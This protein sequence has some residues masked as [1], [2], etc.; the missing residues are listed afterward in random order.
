MPN[1][2]NRKAAQRR[3][4]EGSTRPG[5]TLPQLRA[6]VS[7]RGFRRRVAAAA[8]TLLVLACGVGA[9]LIGR[10]R[11]PSP[12]RMEISE[13]SSLVFRNTGHQG[14]GLSPMCGCANEENPARWWGVSFAARNILIEHHTN[15]PFTNFSVTAA[16]PEKIGLISNAA[17]RLT[18]TLIVA[19]APSQSSLDFDALVRNGPQPGVDILRREDIESD[20]VAF[21]TGGRLR[22]TLRSDTPLGAWLPRS[23]SAMA[24]NMTQSMF[25]S[26]P[27]RAVLTEHYPAWPERVMKDIK[28]GKPLQY[29]EY[30]LADFLGPN[31]IFWTTEKVEIVAAGSYS[32]SGTR[33]ETAFSSPAAEQNRDVYT[34]VIV[35]R[36][37]FAARVA[38]QPVDANFAERARS[39]SILQSIDEEGRIELVL[40]DHDA[41]VPNVGAVYGTLRSRKTLRMSDIPVNPTAHG[42]P[43]KPVWIHD[44]GFTY[45][46]GPPQGGFNVFG[47]VEWLGFNGAVGRVY[48]ENYRVI[49]IGVPS[50]IELGDIKM[51]RR[52]HGALNLPLPVAPEPAIFTLDATATLT[53]NGARPF[54]LPKIFTVEGGLAVF[55]VVTT[56]MSL[57]LAWKAMPRQPPG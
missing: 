18:A 39:G 5:N 54:R 41:D 30:S 55:T 11:Q 13:F 52:D 53:I 29:A 10:G 9:I 26:N 49:D 4:T 16:S 35:T 22:V 7:R 1:T 51:M 31:V 32:S 43:D 38:V 44:V 56:I 23:H 40:L 34:I 19:S 37:P 42:L 2:R 6:A 12:L 33:I 28:L 27:S 8:T 21:V 46:P 47:D 36:P 15:K 45:P 14:F 25:A 17:L 3:A 57:I 24:L 20:F 48:G 50:A